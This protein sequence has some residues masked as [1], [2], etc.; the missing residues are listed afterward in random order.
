MIIKQYLLN[1]LCFNSKFYF[2]NMHSP[3]T[4]SKLSK[5]IINHRVV[6]FPIYLLDSLEL[7]F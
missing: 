2:T 5:N 4:S 1:D 3:I 7:N 6:H